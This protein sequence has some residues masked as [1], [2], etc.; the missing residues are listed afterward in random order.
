MEA[1]MNEK[2]RCIVNVSV[3]AWY[4]RGQKRLVDSLFGK[5][6]ADVGYWNCWPPGSPPHSVMPFAF[7]SH[8]LRLAREQG[9]RR[10]L[11]LD[12]SC[13]AVRSLET[14]WEKIERDGFLF[15]NNGYMLGEWSSDYCLDM[16]ALTRDEAMKLGD[17]TAMMFGLDLDNP[18]VA[19]WLAD[20]EQ[21]CHDPRLMNG[22]L[23]QHIGKDTIDPHS[24]YNCGVISHDPR[25]RGH[26]REQVVAGLLMHRHGLLPTSNSP[27]Y[28]IQGW[29]DPTKPVPEAAVI[30]SCGM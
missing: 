15:M 7:K 27:Q 2:K 24:G 12:A 13:W 28:L 20:F 14:V 22:S 26:A 30:L 4:P 23:H 19:C 18:R 29:N 8:A 21:L 16:F 17:M 11:W 9:Y 6:C 25:C 5:S 3:G 1:Q 10:L